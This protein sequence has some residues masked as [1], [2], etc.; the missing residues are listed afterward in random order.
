MD[1]GARHGRNEAAGSPGTLANI[2]ILSALSPRELTLLAVECDWRDISRNE[3]ILDLAQGGT[4]PGVS[5]VVKGAVRLS[6]S[7]GVAGRITYSDV[8]AGQQ[9]GEMSIFGVM[10]TDLTA[11]AREDS[12][13]ATM[14]ERRFIELLSREESVSRALLCQYARALRMQAPSD[15]APEVAARRSEGTGAQRVY[16]E[17]L[18]LAEPGSRADGGD[19]LL[20]ARLPRH[21]ELA[22][23]L[24][25]TEETVA[26]AIAELVRAGVAARDYPGLVIAD[27]AALKALCNP[28]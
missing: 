18:A 4:L 19:C 8:G 2:G 21:R 24:D 22:A 17:L 28:S 1:S 14:P 16:G 12:T 9:F 5:F 11:V 15:P 6:R 23:R 3:I 10:E 26:R 13:I 27:E 25:T 7:T 20:I